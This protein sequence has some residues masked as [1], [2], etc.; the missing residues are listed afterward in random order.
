MAYKQ[1]DDL[2]IE[3]AKI[4]FRNFSGKQ[5]EYNR[6][7]N[8]NFCVILEDPEIAQQLAKDKWN[9]KILAGREEGEEARYYLP[10]QASYDN[11]PP[12]IVLV[13]QRNKTILDEESLS[14]L[15]FAEI[16]NVDIIIRPYSWE[17]NG[18]TGIKAYVKSM[19]VTIEEDYFE[20]KYAM[21]EAPVDEEIPF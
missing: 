2:I 10:V 8:R 17:A 15:D 13:T 21:E 1:I 12:K 14:T 9:V 7:G 18:R 4:I 3:N 20:A 6:A 5:T 16:N 19:W 11:Y